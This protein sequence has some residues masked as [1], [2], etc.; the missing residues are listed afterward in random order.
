MLTIKARW[1]RFIGAVAALVAIAVV[2]CSLARADEPKKASPAGKANAVKEQKVSYDKQ[3]RPILQ[4]Q[5]Q[6]C[7]QPAKAGGGYVM[8]SF[9]LHAQ[10]G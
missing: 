3:I 10:R 9:D 1:G 2:S 6:G 8:T 7:H 5:C 4:A